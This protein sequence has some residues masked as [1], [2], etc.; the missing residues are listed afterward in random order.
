MVYDP[1][2]RNRN[3]KT[4]SSSLVRAFAGL[5]AVMTF[6]VIGTKVFTLEEEQEKLQKQIQAYDEAEERVAVR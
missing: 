2:G 1:Y 4:S 5:L 6:V 3:E